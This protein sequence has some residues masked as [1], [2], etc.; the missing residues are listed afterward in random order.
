MRLVTFDSRS[1]DSAAHL[2]CLSGD[3][4]IDLTAAG[5]SVGGA[6][7]TVCQSMDALVKS[8]AEGL[9]IAKQV[10]EKEGSNPK[11]RTGL[12]DVYLRAPL[13]YPNQIFAV[14]RNYRE[15]AE[16]AGAAL[17]TMPRLFPK[18]PS[19]VIGPGA[20]V[21]KPSRTE[22]LDWEVELAVVI[23]RDASFVSAE[24]A[25]DHVFGYTIL[26]DV[27]ARDIQ[28]SKPEQ[29]TLA[30]NFRT[31]APL[32][33]WILTRDEV[34]NPGKLSV[35]SWV[36]GALMQDSTTEY[37]IFDVPTLVSFISEVTDLHP[38]D[39]IS[40]GTPSGVGCFRE[41]P[42]YLNDGDVMKM[43]LAQNDQVLC[44][45]INQVSSAS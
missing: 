14:G 35:R 17:P 8:G 30:K 43:Q 19:T 26:N 25:L 9:G 5:H 7:A 29:L 33:G 12:Q 38:G 37:L 21:I 42:I 16:E 20:A 10:V 23:G 45:L 31:F 32:G 22:Q 3:V 2:G 18:W 41:P 13:P 6:A 34:P 11:L 39:I 24:R 27:S 36:N 15:H 40:T 28:F 44:E 1:S 4:V